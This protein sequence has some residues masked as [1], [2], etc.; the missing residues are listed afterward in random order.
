MNGRWNTL[1]VFALVFSAPVFVIAQ[2]PV[3]PAAAGGAV[4]G[5]VDICVD[6]N[7]EYQMGGTGGT[8][9]ADSIC[10][11]DGTDTICNYRNVGTGD[12]MAKFAAGCQA[13]PDPNTF[14]ICY[15]D[16]GATASTNARFVVENDGTMY[17]QILTSNTG[18]PGYIFGDPQNSVVAGILYKHFTDELRVRVAGADKLMW[19]SASLAYQGA[20]TFTTTAGD[21]TF[22][23]A[24]AFNIQA[25]LNI[26]TPK[27]A[28]TSSLI[29]TESV[30][31]A[32][33]PGDANK[34]T[35]G[36]II[37]NGVDLS[38]VTTRV[39]TAGTNCT[40]F[41]I[42]DGADVDLWGATISPVDTTTTTN[43]NA[44]STWNHPNL[45][46]QEIT[47]TSNGGNCFD[48][49]LAISAHYAD[50]SAATAD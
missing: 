9:T 19:T 48:L 42:G 45:A 7:V 50:A 12:F 16:S 46:D 44:T 15:G 33:N 3:D 22:N 32:A 4:G 26:S 29:N 27:G 17:I 6:D 14:H 8:C 38:H 31:F 18:L 23:P 11:Y 1:L 35:I 13:S 20:T 10:F 5:T 2:T 40:S 47:I 28:I 24:G 37:P 21:L 49:I 43:A 41:S 25:D 39:V 30:T 36:T 34:V